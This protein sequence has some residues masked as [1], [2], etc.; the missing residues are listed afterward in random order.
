MQGPVPDQFNLVVTDMDATVACRR[1]RGDLHAPA[2]VCILCRQ[3][4]PEIGRRW[5]ID[6]E[7]VNV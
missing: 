5:K 1:G 3:V 7:Q 2:P 6:R 4:P